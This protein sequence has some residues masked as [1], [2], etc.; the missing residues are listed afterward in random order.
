MALVP[1][2]CS[3]DMRLTLE[4]PIWS[5]V[6]GIKACPPVQSRLYRIKGL[7]STKHKLTQSSDMAA[8]NWDLPPQ[9]ESHVLQASIKLP[10]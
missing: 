3:L 8:I 9:L 7:D 6:L 5:F 1:G 4:G 10:A 2:I